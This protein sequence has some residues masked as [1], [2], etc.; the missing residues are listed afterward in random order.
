MEDVCFMSRDFFIMGV[1]HTL[2]T[3]MGN[4]RFVILRTSGRK[5]GRDGRKEETEGDEDRRYL[6]NFNFISGL[7]TAIL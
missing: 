6:L 1:Q 5:K 2:V 4:G 7:H 3:I